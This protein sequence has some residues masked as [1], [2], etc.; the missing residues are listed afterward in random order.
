MVAKQGDVW[1]ALHPPLRSRVNVPLLAGCYGS[2]VNVPWL[3]GCYGSRPNVPSLRLKIFHQFIKQFRRKLKIEILNSLDQPLASR[4]RS[5]VID[6]IKAV[7]VV[8]LEN[9]L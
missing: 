6:E 5:E 3:A 9:R 2:R 8:V 4:N 7:R 1:S